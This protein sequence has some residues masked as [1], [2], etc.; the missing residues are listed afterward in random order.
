MSAPN[1]GEFVR[2]IEPLRR[3]LLAHCYRM[4]GS[5]DDAEDLVQE[6]H[7][8]AWRAFGSFQGRS[9]FRTWIHTIATNA[10]LSALASRK[11]RVLP[12]GLG[13]ASD[14]PHAPPIE[15]ESDVSWLQPIPDELLD[16]RSEDPAALFVSR[17]TLRLALIASLQCL[18]VRQRAALLLTEVLAFSA[19]EV[20]DMLGV[21]LAAVKSMLQRARARLD[22]VVPNPDA[23]LEPSG[24]DAQALLERY[25]RAF[26]RSD[27]K[28]L[29]Q[30]LCD[31]ATLEVTRSRTWFI[32]KR[33]CVPYIAS[34]ALASPGDWKMVPTTANGQPAVI[35]YLRQGGGV[36]EPFGVA[37]LTVRSGAIAGIVVFADPSIVKRFEGA[38][39]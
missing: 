14:D 5:V 6:T 29:E 35:A 3:E 24:P 34:H 11:R 37:V 10:C 21:S 7:L 32:G 19:A 38:R 13:R 33:T 26:E 39:S 28:A 23:I 2:Q 17:E 15:A 1:H 20:A 16:P 18:P 31:D 12:S 9:S 30:L 8:R 25:T 27:P 36:H 22:R 4:L